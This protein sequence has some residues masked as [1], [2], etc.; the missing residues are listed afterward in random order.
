MLDFLACVSP[1]K[2]VIDA[3]AIGMAKRMLQGIK[4]LTPTLA[5]DM[6]EDIDFKGDFLKQKATRLL[7]KE[8]QYF[9]SYV[10]DRGS[11]RSWLQ[12]GSPDTFARAKVRVREIITAYQLPEIPKIQVDA[13]ADLVTRLA[14]KAG[15]SEL[16]E[17]D[18]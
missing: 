18:E 10:I 13:L 1:E 14:K 15:M 16:P 17:V 4:E 2:L 5:V 8:E 6:F 3:E 12:N 9:P 7:L 11:I